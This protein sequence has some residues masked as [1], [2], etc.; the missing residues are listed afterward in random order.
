MAAYAT[1]MLLAVLSLN[2]QEEIAETRVGVQVEN[3]AAAR[4]CKFK[5]GELP[6][7]D[8]GVVQLT[9]SAAGTHLLLLY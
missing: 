7:A 3:I 5:S 6:L 9:G 1:Q 2:H 4:M 8:L